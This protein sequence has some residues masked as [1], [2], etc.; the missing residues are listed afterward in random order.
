MSLHL[1]APAHIKEAPEYSISPACFGNSQE[2]ALL[3]PEQLYDVGGTVIDASSVKL[4]TNCF[5]CVSLGNVPTAG[6]QLQALYPCT[7]IINTYGQLSC[8]L[9]LVFLEYRGTTKYDTLMR[10]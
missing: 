5:I 7:G 8:L 1:P 6:L 2:V 3:D 4:R 9:Q 10:C